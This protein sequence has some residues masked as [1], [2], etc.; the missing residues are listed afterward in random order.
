MTAPIGVRERF[1]EMRAMLEANGIAE[2]VMMPG[3][4]DQVAAAC[5]RDVLEMGLDPGTE[6]VEVGVAA[7]LALGM[8]ILLQNAG[9]PIQLSVYAKAGDVFL[10][11]LQRGYTDIGAM[12][13]VEQV[14]AGMDSVTSPAETAPEALPEHTCQSCGC[15]AS[16][17]DSGIWWCQPCAAYLERARQLLA[18]FGTPAAHAPRLGGPGFD[19]PSYPVPTP[20]DPPAAVAPGLLGVIEQW[21]HNRRQGRQEESS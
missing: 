16:I 21:L 9:T 11:S 3:A 14:F 5:R 2:P 18:K 19:L 13:D 15:A 4:E 7:G 17:E 12:G 8:K 10:D 20:P 1:A 6:V